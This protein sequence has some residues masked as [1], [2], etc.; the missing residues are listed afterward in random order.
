L[1]DSRLFLF[2]P[3]GRRR[4]FPSQGRSG[5]KR[6]G[7]PSLPG[8]RQ[9]YISG[10]LFP[11]FSDSFLSLLGGGGPPPQTRVR[12]P[13][14]RRQRKG[15][16]SVGSFLTS[17]FSF[18]FSPSSVKA[19]FR[20]GRER[21]VSS[22]SGP[23]TLSPTLLPPRSLFFFLRRYAKRS[24]PRLFFFSKTNF[25]IC[26]C[27]SSFFFSSGGGFFSGWPGIYISFYPRFFFEINFLPFPP[28]FSFLDTSKGKR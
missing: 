27:R 19:P 5:R 24:T 14:S 26:C 4:G 2:P 22:L 7:R 17:L 15:P 6:L 28:L 16:F 25:W 1:F 12:K 10:P 3:A 21:P 23:P 11:P 13:F 9:R 18:F 20:S 8:D